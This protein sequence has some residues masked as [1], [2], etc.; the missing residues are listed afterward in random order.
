MAKKEPLIKCIL[1]VSIGGRT[2]EDIPK[3]ISKGLGH[4]AA[5]GK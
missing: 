4:V 2:F 3:K 5:L 1:L